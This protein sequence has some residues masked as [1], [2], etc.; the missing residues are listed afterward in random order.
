MHF[1]LFL[2]RDAFGKL[3]R[4]RN[5]F[6][7]HTLLHW[8]TGIWLDKQGR[9]QL[10]QLPEATIRWFFLCCVAWV[11]FSNC[12][13]SAGSVLWVLLRNAE[14]K[15]TPNLRCSRFLSVVRYVFR[16]ERHILQKKNISDKTKQIYNKWTESVCPPPHDS[17]HCS[18]NSMGCSCGLRINVATCNWSCVDCLFWPVRVVDKVLPDME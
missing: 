7:R 1:Q 15:N 5:I 9:L 13:I 4:Q 6:K 14:D 8:S 18:R 11:V 3:T 10:E 12:A 17:C 16:M 2:R